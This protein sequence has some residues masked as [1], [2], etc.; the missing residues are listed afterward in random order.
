ML[1]LEGAASFQP[2]LR[3]HL[4]R[5]LER[6][7]LARALGLRADDLLHLGVI[8]RRLGENVEVVLFVGNF[9]FDA[10]DEQT[11]DHLMIKRAVTC[12]YAASLD[13]PIFG[14]RSLVAPAP[15]LSQSQPDQAMRS[16]AIHPIQVLSAAGRLYFCSYSCR[17]RLLFGRIVGVL[18]VPV[19]REQTVRSFRTHAPEIRG[20][21]GNFRKRN[22]ALHAQFVPLFQKRGD[23]VARHPAHN[24]VRFGG[25]D[26][27]NKGAVVSRVDWHLVG[28]HKP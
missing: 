19:D 6:V 26:L 25:T 23:I 20:A 27:E 4:T 14:A 3:R 12:L 2:E 10:D 5:D 11:I 16:V 21:D 24:D 9:G 15:S 1:P 28:A 13:A 17:H 22:L 18:V 8:R 7:H